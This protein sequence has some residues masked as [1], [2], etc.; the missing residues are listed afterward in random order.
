MSIYK[1]RLTTKSK[2][3]QMKTKLIKLT[4]VLPKKIRDLFY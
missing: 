2:K 3:H 1:K 4:G